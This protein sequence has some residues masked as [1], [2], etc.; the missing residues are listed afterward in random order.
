MSEKFSFNKL[1]YDSVHRAS[2]SRIPIRQLTSFPVCSP[3][4]ILDRKRDTLPKLET[5]FSGNNKKGSDMET[6]NPTRGRGGRFC[7]P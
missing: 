3:I 6:V 1:E 2:L 7:P 5:G 4:S